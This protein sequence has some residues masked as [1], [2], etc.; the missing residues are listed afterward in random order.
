MEEIQMY[1]EAIINLSVKRQLTFDCKCINTVLDQV[2]HN[3]NGEYKL[4]NY[5]T[6]NSTPDQ[7]RANIDYEDTGY[8]VHLLY[9]AIIQMDPENCVDQLNRYVTWLEEQNNDPSFIWNSS[10]QNNSPFQSLSNSF[11]DNPF[12]NSGWVQPP[13]DL[14]KSPYLNY[15]RDESKMAMVA[16]IREKRMKSINNQIDNQPA[17]DE[18]TDNK[19]INNQPACEFM[20]NKFIGNKSIDNDKLTDNKLI[21]NKSIDNKLINNKSIDNKLINNKS[22]DNKLINKSIDN[23][24]AVIGPKM[25]VG[26]PQL[27]FLK[28]IQAAELEQVVIGV[29]NAKYSETGNIDNSYIYRRMC[30][31]LSIDSMNLDTTHITDII[32]EYYPYIPPIMNKDT[33]KKIID[34]ITNGVLDTELMA[35]AIQQY[36]ALLYDILEQSGLVTLAN[37]YGL[38]KNETLNSDILMCIELR[39]QF[40]N[41]KNKTNMKLL[42]K[43]ASDDLIIKAY[44]DICLF[45]LDTHTYLREKGA[46]DYFDYKKAKKGVRNCGKI[47]LKSYNNLTSNHL[48]KAVNKLSIKLTK[49]IENCFRSLGTEF[50]LPPRLIEKEYVLLDI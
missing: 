16:K 31:C 11:S 3:T 6:K 39:D 48:I 18:L 12:A 27:D 38:T 8:Q 26:Y 2:L 21:N 33:H 25:P 47:V 45:L 9:K 42:K 35:S 28:G 40:I 19:P 13:S 50:Y 4:L 36:E 10:F 37:K 43:Q 29:C 49:G 14:I 30:S 20:N 46:I 44:V 41:M 15:M 24:V 7:F 17:T 22:I 5:L 32:L 23:K 34:D 1:A